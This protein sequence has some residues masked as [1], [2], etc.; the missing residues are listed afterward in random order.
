M[1]VLEREILYIVVEE[2]LL[3]SNTELLDGKKQLN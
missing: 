3:K 1:S 2:L